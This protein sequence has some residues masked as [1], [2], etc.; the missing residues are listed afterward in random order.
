MLCDLKSELPVIEA[1][2]AVEILW[3]GLNSG[4]IGPCEWRVMVKRYSTRLYVL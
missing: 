4:V 1:A 2:S 3:I